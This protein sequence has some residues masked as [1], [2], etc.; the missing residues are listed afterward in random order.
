M[1]SIF[2]VLATTIAVINII[3]K[4]NIEK[5]AKETISLV[6]SRG[7]MDNKINYDP[8]V[9]PP[10]QDLMEEHYFIVGFNDD[11][12]VYDKD[13]IH[14]FTITEEYGTLLATNIYSEG[15][16]NGKIDD[17]RWGRGV[18]ED[19]TYIAFVDLKDHIQYFKNFLTISTSVSAGCY[20]LIFGLILLAS[21]IAFITSEDSFKKQKTFI[22]NA[23]HELKTPLTIIS[24]DLEI[25][26]MDY[27]KNE[28]TES[29]RDQINRLTNM[30]NQLVT[31]A[32]LNETDT[33]NYEFSEFDL[34]SLA[35][36]CIDAFKPS[37]ERAGFK[38]KSR[39]SQNLTMKGNRFLINEMIYI[40]LDNALKYAKAET[41]IEFKIE[42]TKDKLSFKFSN[43]AEGLEELNTKLMFER[44]YRSSNSTK[45]GSGIGLSIAQ[46]IV[47]LHKGKINATVEGNKITFTMLF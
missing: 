24:T 9:P 42:K 33:H 26:E 1:I 4:H 12:T 17:L 13:F 43:E 32:R 36:E 22:T 35:H 25:I 23:S 30:T 41:T 46:E 28:W 27:G 8:S 37:Y 6:L 34:T 45:P 38:L 29:I 20:V 7:T 5:K 21:K 39:I 3:N 2:F 18:K 47:Q 15:K 16:Q 14:I 19:K 11:G 40:F 31:L 10:P 44:F